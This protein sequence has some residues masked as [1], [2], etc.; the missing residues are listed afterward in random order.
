MAIIFAPVKSIRIVR[1]THWEDNFQLVDEASQTPVS[2]VG[3]TGLLMRVRRSIG[4][5]I[6][7]ELSLPDSGLDSAGRLVLVDATTGMVG[8]RVDTPATLTL[9]EN[10]HRKAKYGYDSVI[11]RTPGEYE[12][13][14]RGKLSV[15]PQYTRPW[16]T[17]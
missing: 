4:S 8:F 16:G 13:A 11:E 14:A 2:L 1:G 17:T 12:A 9:P 6:L 10:G 15:L 5:P 7:L 3:I